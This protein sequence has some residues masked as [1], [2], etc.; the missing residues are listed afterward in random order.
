MA[1]TLFDLDPERAA[2]TDRLRALVAPVA[3]NAGAVLDDPI[4]LELANTIWAAFGEMDAAGG[5]THAQIAHACA[6][7]CPTDVFESRFRVFHELGMLQPVF[8]KAHQMRYVFNPTSAAGLM[9]FDRLAVRG[10]VDELITL[11]DRTRADL[12]AG[13]AN[14]DQVRDALRM[15]QRMLTISADHLLRLVFTS[16]LSELI[17]QRR[18]HTHEGLID[19]VRRLDAQVTELFP[20]LDEV[21]FRLVQEAQRYV[22]ARERFVTRLLDEGAVARDFSLLDPEQYL[23]AA[24]AASLD[25]L[26]EVFSCVVV[27]P[28]QVWLDPA[29]LARTVADFTPRAP[30]RRRPPRPSDPPVGA[31]PIARVRERAEEARRRRVR[32]A[33]MFLQ[34][35]AYVELTS[36]LRAA[37]WPSAATIVAQAVAVGRDP[38]LAYE[39][40]TTDEVIVDPA[41][42]VTHVSPVTLHRTSTVQAIDDASAAGAA[43]AVIGDA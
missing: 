33:E 6:K 12:D 22:S 16:P 15:A 32:A 27:D 2:Y 8:D 17:A 4:S 14:V 37:G 23:E 11:L 26:A 36:A 28:P 30:V 25:D 21:T 43:E 39:V 42:P 18:H 1:E 3:A 9:V 13:R 10:G 19:D 24:R 38:D 41:G 35:A 40:T 34:G 5:L 29:V 20:E 7:V 31:D